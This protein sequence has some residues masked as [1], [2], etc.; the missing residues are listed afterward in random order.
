MREGALD[1]REELYPLRCMS[2]VKWTVREVSLVR[3]AEE[4]ACQG[5]NYDSYDEGGNSLRQLLFVNL[6]GLCA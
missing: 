4:I 3:M 6:R 1:R 5:V 2:L